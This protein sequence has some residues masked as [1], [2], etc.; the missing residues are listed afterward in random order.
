MFFVLSKTVG[1]LAEPTF[2]I[3]VLLL[4]GAALM[5]TRFKRAGGRLV[6][7]GAALLL[8][9][10]FLPLGNALILPLE[11][12]F[13]K[14]DIA[15][16]AAV[17]GIVLLGGAEDAFVSAGRGI[18]AFNEAGERLT[19]AL[20]LAR[21]LPRARIVFSGGSAELVVETS[22]GADVARRF[23]AEQGL[24]ADRIVFEGKARNTHENAVF[25][26]VAAGPKPGERWLLVTSAYHMPRSIGCF[27]QAGFA[28]EP[29]PVDYRTSGP[30]DSWRRF[31]RPIEGLRRVD[32]AAR[33]WAGL[34]F[35]WLT[36]RTNA[37]LPA[38]SPA[39]PKG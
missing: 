20:V 18:V 5:W 25:S 7:A 21:R 16:G 9:A 1:L 2:L 33:E 23:F 39:R 12:R 8:V 28:V 31:H 24:A 37:L 13:A 27:R 17:D 14:A 6:L 3:A 35:Y 15:S 38:P 32:L 34:L 36:G 30:G 11:E 29:W 10:G 22:F 26:K 19:E 4:T